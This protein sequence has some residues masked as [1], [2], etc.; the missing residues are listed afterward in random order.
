MT[1]KFR[2]HKT[3]K[4]IRILNRLEI[5]RRTNIDKKQLLPQYINITEED[6]IVYVWEENEKNDIIEVV[7]VSYETLIGKRWITVVRYDSEHGFLHRHQRISLDDETEIETTV[8]V[9][10]KGT[11]KAW[12]TW[13]VEELKNKCWDYKMGFIKGSLKKKYIDK[14]R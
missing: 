9:K 14:K 6:R 13:A 10:K 4:K 12:L 11:A 3:H 1:R 5:K 7:N 2:K 8:G